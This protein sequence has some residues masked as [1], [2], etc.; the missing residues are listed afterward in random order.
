MVIPEYPLK[1]FATEI[2]QINSQ[3]SNH[4]SFSQPHGPNSSFNVKTTIYRNQAFHLGQG[5]H[6]HINCWMQFT[7]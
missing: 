7:S 6:R 4:F 3:N 1:T 2:T 5:H